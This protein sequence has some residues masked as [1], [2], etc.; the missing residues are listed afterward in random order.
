MFKFDLR[1]YLQALLTS[2]DRLSMAF[3]VES[4]VPLLDHRI[5][6]LAGRIGA[7]SKTVPG[8]S[9]YLLRQALEGIIP[10][11]ILSR[12]DKRGFPTPIGKWLRDP[13][14]NLM[15]NLVFESNSFAERYFDLTH[16]KRMEQARTYGSSDATERLWRVLNVCVWGEVFNLS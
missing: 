12:R 6:E 8:R 10:A 3:S 7:E 11:E 15:E 5:A 14:L 13:G 16:L 1:H 2:E 9:K 4:R